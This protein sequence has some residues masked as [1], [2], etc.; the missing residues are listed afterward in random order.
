MSRKEFEDEFMSMLQDEI[1]GKR[2]R[3]TL[4]DRPSIIELRNDN[5]GWVIELRYN[6]EICSILVWTNFDEDTIAFETALSNP[7]CVQEVCYVIE[8]SYETNVFERDSKM[9][10]KRNNKTRIAN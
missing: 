4:Q 10:R 5:N 1:G 7:N 6:N 2:R 3:I 8:D 9:D